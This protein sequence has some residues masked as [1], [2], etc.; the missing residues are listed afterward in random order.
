MELQD[1]RLRMN[2]KP[3]I[4]ILG[5][6]KFR[7][8]DGFWRSRNKLSNGFWITSIGVT[9]WKL[10]PKQ[11]NEVWQRPAPNWRRPA[12]NLYRCIHL[13][14]TRSQVRATRSQSNRRISRSFT[15]I[16][17]NLSHRLRRVREITVVTRRRPAPIWQRAV[18]R[19]LWKIVGQDCFCE[20]A[21]ARPQLA[22]D[23]SRRFRFPAV[24]NP[25]L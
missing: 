22:A 18:T 15:E 10:W 6:F 2:F 5:D 20:S 13:G 16:R 23:R 14:T 19:Q 1:R 4:K 17:T 12:P 24:S 9:V 3:G 25:K 7:K 21:T 8:P 11:E